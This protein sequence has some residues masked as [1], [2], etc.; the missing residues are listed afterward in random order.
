MQALEVTFVSTRDAIISIGVILGA[1]AAIGRYIVRPVVNF[2]RR[3]EKVMSNVE[4]Q[5]YPN[6]GS[7]LRDAVN[8]IQEHLGID[9]ESPH[10]PNPNHPH[11]PKR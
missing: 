6:G 11:T 2:G 8:R 10:E 3:L 1:L 4:K 9:D 5:L 7:T